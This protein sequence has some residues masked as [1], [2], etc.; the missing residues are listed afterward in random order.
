MNVQPNRPSL[1]IA[2][3]GSLNP[4]LPMAPGTGGASD[5]RPDLGAHGPHLRSLPSNW[6]RSMF[7]CTRAENDEV[8]PPATRRSPQRALAEGL[9]LTAVQ[10]WAEKI[11]QDVE[12]CAAAARQVTR[13]AD[14]TAPYKREALERQQE[15]ALALKGRVD[16]YE[17]TMRAL[18][19]SGLRNPG[20]LGRERSL[21]PAERRAIAPWTNPVA[22][23][24]AQVERLIK[25]L[26]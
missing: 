16:A 9:A 4:D 11:A 20:D 12:Q 5:P 10:A 19:A 14:L 15:Q 1:A 17:A 13:R 7:S 22:T 3:A 21:T 2:P 24:R 25:S 26:G 23:A 18:V 6:F 8:A